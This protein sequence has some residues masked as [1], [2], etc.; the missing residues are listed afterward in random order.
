MHPISAP[1]PNRRMKLG[2]PLR[3]LLAVDPPALL[4]RMADVVR[5][6]E[7]LELAG[8]FSAAPQAI[9]WTLWDR[10][11][12]HLAFVDLGLQGGDVRPLVQRLQ[13]QPRAGTVVALGDHLWDE[14]REGCAGM[15]IHQLLEKGDV[16]AFRDFLELKVR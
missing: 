15:G 1:A 9:D 3:V 10:Q 4:L 13:Q 7:G 12:C 16:V 5:S 6:I 11:G 2:A 8:A 14:I